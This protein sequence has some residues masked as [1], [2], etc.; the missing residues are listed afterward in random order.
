M[1][2]FLRFL[3]ILSLLIV[4]VAPC[5]RADDAA[6]ARRRYNEGKAAL[7]AG[8]FREAA[9][10]FEATSRLRKHGA[11]PYAAAMAWDKAEEPSRA[12]DNFHLA[13]ETPGLDKK[14]LKEAKK[15][16]EMLEQS[17]GTVVVT[18]PEE[19]VVQFDG[20]TEANPPARLHATPGINTLLVARGDKIERRDLKLVA[21]EVIDV[22]VTEPIE[23]PE[24]EP[25]PP[26]KEEPIIEE[27][28]E[29]VVE[30]D[31]SSGKTRK[32]IGYTAI[33]AGVVSAGVA[34]AMGFK[35][36]SARD[37]FEEQR[38]RETYDSATSARMWTN[39]AWAGAVVFGGVGT[40]LVLWPDKDKGNKGQE[41]P[42]SGDSGFS[43]SP[44][45]NGLLLRGSF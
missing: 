12:A 32:L 4:V 6:E 36:L 3:S 13:I 42:D 33:G 24:P 43:L 27:E 29:P 19:L 34:V 18:G 17:L 10:H 39:V 28:P 30:V 25:P 8:R 16:L 1:N 11:A 14:S 38:T 21:G 26:P 2:T 5:A 23:E 44:T 41:D 7:D 9:L 22:D 45:P 35:T 31:P 37:D 20:S 40:A 15:R